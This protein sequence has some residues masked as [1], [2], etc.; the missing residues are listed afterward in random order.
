[1]E[2]SRHMIEEKTIIK[3]ENR[4][5]SPSDGHSSVSLKKSRKIKRKFIP[6]LLLL[7]IPMAIYYGYNWVVFRL[8][9]VVTDDAQ[10]K[11]DL[12]IVSSKVGGRI[13]ELF[14]DEGD[15]LEIGQ[16]MVALD[17]REH[18]ETLLK[19]R[20]SWEN[21]LN[22]L[23]RARINLQLIQ[24]KVHQGIAEAQ[25]YLNQSKE[26]L[27]M[28]REDTRLREEK[29][30]KEV[31]RAEAN[32]QIAKS[33]SLESQSELD[34][35]LREAT[36]AKTLFE[37]GIL[38]ETEKDN[39]ETDLKT[40]QARFDVTSKAEMEAKAA[41]EQAKSELRTITLKKQQE[42]VVEATQKV[43]SI[44]LNKAE[45]ETA[46]VA[47]QEITVKA[48]QARVKEAE[49]Q[50]NLTFLQL[51][52][53]KV[54][55]PEQGIVARRLVRLGEIIQPGQPLFVINNPK[56]V[57]VV[58]N[59]EET[60]LEKIKRG[61]PVLVSVDA[62]PETPFEGKVGFIGSA[63]TSELALFSSDNP[64]RNFIKVIH[65]IP[66]RI[67]LDNSNGFLRP[68]MNANVA[69]KIEK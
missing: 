42:K 44:Q 57:W 7:A 27:E 43:A 38:S 13:E 25:T 16:P 47:I 45:D 52:E 62:F 14:V 21:L 48:L 46:Q 59:L 20:A 40:F 35:A 30:R 34:K 31:E 12:I 3:E 2:K 5:P 32:F 1:M 53:T 29:V 22:E 23:E 68:G 6:F 66:I 61:S 4:L 51:E 56:K 19:A 33:R 54:N 39:R 69:I 9:Y 11:S 50:Y 8:N 24:K 41:L 64:S 37:E 65:R 49:A 67:V 55:S 28:A 10:V 18:R 17:S 36:K 26:S 58:A 63:S 15:S 60:K